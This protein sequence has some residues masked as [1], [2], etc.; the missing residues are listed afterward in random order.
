MVF[1]SI[2]FLFYFL[3]ITLA[4]YYILPNKCRNIVLLVASL[5]FYAYGEPT[6]VFIMILSIVFTYI[7]GLINSRNSQSCF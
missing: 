4:F 1:S 6:Y 5:V 2:T 7:Y 3:P